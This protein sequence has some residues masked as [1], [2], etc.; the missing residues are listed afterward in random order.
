MGPQAGTPEA[1]T[2]A[3][4][5]ILENMIEFVIS[6][7]FINEL[8]VNGSLFMPHYS[9]LM[10]GGLAKAWGRIWGAAAGPTM[11]LEP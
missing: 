3:Q 6:N 8:S 4:A 9:R 5:L 7:S 2:K 1:F 10:A 11:S